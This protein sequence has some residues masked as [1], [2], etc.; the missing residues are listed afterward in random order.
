[1]YRHR[2]SLANLR[3]IFQKAEEMASELPYLVSRSDSESSLHLYREGLQSLKSGEVDISYCYR[4]PPVALKKNSGSYHSGH[5]WI[6]FWIIT[7][8]NVLTGEL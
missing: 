6:K 7:L 1:M 5:S 3:A 2:K 8:K 4:T